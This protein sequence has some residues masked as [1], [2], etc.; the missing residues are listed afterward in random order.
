MDRRLLLLLGVLLTVMVAAAAV[1]VLDRPVDDL[2]PLAG[3]LGAGRRPMPIET[4]IAAPAG[5]LLGAVFV[6]LRMPRGGSEGAEQRRRWSQ[7]FLA[8]V[9]VLFA[10][11]EGVEIGAIYDWFP[12]GEIPSR[13]LLAAA[14][15]WMMFGANSAAKLI[16]LSRDGAPASPRR[17]TLN[18]FS[19][20]GGVVLGLVLVPVSLWAPLNELRTVWLI[21]PLVLVLLYLGRAMTLKGRAA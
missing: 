6:A 3:H 11:L 10:A 18:R 7:T 8:G 1:V 4:L 13:L 16:V 12:A 15:L 21:A 20:L 5:L 2:V 17:L 9:A 19:A 14:A